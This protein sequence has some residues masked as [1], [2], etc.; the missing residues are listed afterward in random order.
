MAVAFFTLLSSDL[1]SKY[2]RNKVEAATPCWLCR[3]FRRL[4]ELF[5]AL[6]LEAYA[7]TDPILHRHPKLIDLRFNKPQFVSSNATVSN[8]YGRSAN[9]VLPTTS[10]CSP[11]PP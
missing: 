10:P 4:E 11:P 2:V 7:R 8:E 6:V 9:I 1:C 5:G 3:C